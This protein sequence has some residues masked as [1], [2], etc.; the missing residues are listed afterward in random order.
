MVARIP[1]YSIFFMLCPSP[2]SSMQNSSCAGNAKHRRVREAKSRV[3]ASMCQLKY[4]RDCF[5]GL[6]PSRNDTLKS[7]L[8]FLTEFTARIIYAIEDSKDEELMQVL[9]RRIGKEG[10][11]WTSNIQRPTSNVEWKA[12][13]DLLVLNLGIC[14]FPLLSLRLCGGKQVFNLG[15]Q[16]RKLISSDSCLLTFF[17]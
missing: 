5:V 15:W 9:P 13:A 6:C 17:M 2:L 8:L 3:K 7:C 14:F 11:K 10:K 4:I 16:A 1:E 12:K